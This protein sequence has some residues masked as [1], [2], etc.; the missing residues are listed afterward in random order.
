MESVY[1]YRRTGRYT[2]GFRGISASGGMVNSYAFGGARGGGYSYPSFR[3]SR[4]SAYSRTGYG[5]SGYTRRSGFYGRFG[6]GRGRRA[7][8]EKKFWDVSTP[9]TMDT[10]PE[11]VTSLN[12]IPQG[13]SQSQRVGYK[14]VI[15]SIQWRMVASLPAGAN[16]SDDVWL[17]IVQDTQT[18]GA[19][20][21]ASDVWTGNVAGTMLR[22]IMNGDRFKVLAKIKICL[23]AGAGVAGAFDGDVESVEGF[24]KVNIPLV[25]NGATGAIT[26]VKSNGLLLFAGSNVTDDVITVVGNI[27]LRY[28]DQ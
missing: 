9:F 23:D 3:K 2:G 28:T 5:R 18:N 21:A 16:G 11:V 27:R 1:K 4:R 6:T 7:Q 8:I 13:A 10:T 17:W 12:L 14:C 25:F 15:K 24:L 20:A 22:N 19:L 26:E